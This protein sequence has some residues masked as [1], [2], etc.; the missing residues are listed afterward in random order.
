MRQVLVTEEDH[1]VL[2]KGPLRLA[3]PLFVVLL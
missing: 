2:V 3:E 1:Q